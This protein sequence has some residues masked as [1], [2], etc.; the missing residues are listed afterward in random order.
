LNVVLEEA[1]ESLY[2]LETLRDYGVTSP[3]LDLLISEADQIV[4]IFSAS[5][6]TVKGNPHK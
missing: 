5:I 2:W 4:R 1:D 3:N 6:I